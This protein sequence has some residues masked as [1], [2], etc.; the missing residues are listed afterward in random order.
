MMWRN[1][2]PYTLLVGVENV[3]ATV[4]NSTRFYLEIMGVFWN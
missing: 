2:N 4:D 3:S 1:Q